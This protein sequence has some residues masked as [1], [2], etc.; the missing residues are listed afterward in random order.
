MNR[1]KDVIIEV[2]TSFLG[3]NS[4]EDIFDTVLDEDEIE[5]LASAIEEALETKSL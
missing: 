4:D 3:I 2:L 1:R 5:I